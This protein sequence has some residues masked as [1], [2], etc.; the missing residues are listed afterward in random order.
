MR[1]HDNRPGPPFRPTTGRNTPFGRRRAETACGHASLFAC[2]CSACLL[3]RMCCLFA[4]ALLAARRALLACCC[5]ARCCPRA[6]AVP[7]SE[8][9]AAAALLF[10]R[11]HRR[12]ARSP[13]RVLL[14]L[15]APPKFKSY[16]GQNNIIHPSLS[17][18]SR[19]G[20][21]RASGRRETY[22]AWCF[23]RSRPKRWAW[24]VVV[25]DRMQVGSPAAE[26]S[27][28]ARSRQAPEV[29]FLSS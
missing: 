20:G 26:R 8:L 27:V 12:T 2:C 22:A 25:S 16:L 13:A 3:P 19:C 23:G 17:R 21:A 5:S 9:A 7:P 10:A 28:S 18:S 6:R 29:D 11:A 24:P 14:L 15:R 4:A 1:S